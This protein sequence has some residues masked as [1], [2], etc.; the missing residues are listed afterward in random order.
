MATPSPPP[1]SAAPGFERISGAHTDIGAFETQ[2]AG[3]VERLFTPGDD[4]VDLRGVDLESLPG[5]LGTQALAGN[6]TIHLSTT[7]NRG[8]LFLAG[9]GD[10][11]VTGGSAGDRIAGEAGD[12]LLIGGGQADVLRG[13]P[14]NDVLHGRRGLDELHGGARGYGAGVEVGGS[15]ASILSATIVGNSTGGAPGVG[16]IDVS[17]ASFAPAVENSIIAQNSGTTADVLGRINSDGH[18]LFSQLDITGPQPTDIVLPD[19]N[20]GALAD[21]GGPTLTM[22][23]LP[24]S[25]AL[26]AGSDADAIG[27]T[28]QRGTG[29]ARISGGHRHR[30]VRDAAGRRARAP[31]HAR[32]R[33]GRP[34]RGRSRAPPGRPRHA[35][36]RRQRHDSSLDDAE[37]R[38]AVP[39]RHGRRRGD[40]WLGRRPHRR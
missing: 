38:R 17:R 5:A 6:D 14:G 4:T 25:A 12:D 7:Q 36:A 33:H 27:P 2:Q 11:V 23:P 24:G 37:P 29:F 31:V 10:D 9:T 20:L 22:A 15:V 26:D 32:R 1:T 19:A 21:N 28:D 16:G 30:R 13:G 3:G 34:A 40:R 8:E 35:S 18:N 39:R